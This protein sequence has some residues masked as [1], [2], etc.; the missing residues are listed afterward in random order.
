MT[1]E[2]TETVP[3]NQKKSPLRYVTMVLR[4][5]LGFLFV[6]SGLNGFFHF[7]NGPMPQGALE[8]YWEHS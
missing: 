5:L 1:T 4:F 7:V 6:F 2:T 8:L 3:Q